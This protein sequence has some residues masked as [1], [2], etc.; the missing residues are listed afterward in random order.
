MFSGNPSSPRRGRKSDCAGDH[1]QHRRDDLAPARFGFLATVEH[2]VD[3]LVRRVGQHANA[4]VRFL[5]GPRLRDE[6]GAVG[7]QARVAAREQVRERVERRKAR[8]LRRLAQLPEPLAVTT[9]RLL[10]LGPR[11]PESLDAHDAPHA[12]RPD[13]CIQRRDVAAHAVADHR[14]GR[15]GRPDVEQRVEVREIVREPVA[16][17]GPLGATES[18]PVGGDERVPVGHRVDQELER[19]ARVHPAVQQD[20]DLGLL[21]GPARDVVAQAADHDLLVDRG[22]SRLV[23]LRHV[24]AP[25]RRPASIPELRRRYRWA[26]CSR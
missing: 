11:E 1:V 2:G 18:A 26:P 3:P 10:G 13:A 17:G 4:A 22:S 8:E 20:D 21:A 23:G 19:V 25:H 24:R 12:L 15:V 7:R 5:P 16:V 9:R 6:R 14:D